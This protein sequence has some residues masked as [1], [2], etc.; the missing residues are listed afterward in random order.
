MDFHIGF[1]QIIEL[2]TFLF[3]CQILMVI[4]FIAMVSQKKKPTEMI[5][6][7]LAI[8]FIPYLAIPI[9]LIFGIRKRKNNTSK[10]K[11]IRFSNLECSYSSSEKIGLINLFVNEDMAYPTRNN[12]FKLFLN[13]V[14]AYN[15]LISS[16]ANAKKNI[17]MST[18]IFSNDD[19]SKKII[20]LLEIKAK[21]GIKIKILIDSLGSYK[22]YFRPHLFKKLKKLGGMVYFFMPILKSPFRNYINY[23]NHRKIYIFD[24]KIVFSGGM[25]IGQEYLGPSACKNRWDDILFYIKGDAVSRFHDVFSLDWEFATKEIISRNT[26]SGHDDFSYGNNLL[27][28]IPSGPDINYDTVY[29]GLLSLI[30]NAKKRVWIVTPYFVPSDSLFEA[31]II[32]HKRG[33]DVTVVTPIESNHKIADLARSS[34]MRQLQSK[35][36]KIALYHKMIHAKAVLIDG[37]TVMLGSINFDNRSLF[38][39]Y[40]IAL[41]AYQKQIIDA[42]E[43]W[44][45]ELIAESS[46][47]ILS[48]TKIRHLSENLVKVLVP[49]L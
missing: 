40:E 2:H 41:F 27:H 34:Y 33:V 11:K 45:N 38:L 43:L 20:N 47:K 49:L 24:D 14:E 44:M 30:H 19:V 9:Y 17:Y 16:I 8:I 10:K 1:I 26:V 13:G 31:I 21:Q 28:V 6:W 42:I 3:L 12:D 23:R 36:I 25:N 35:G 22:T 39:N 29:N 32:A 18:Y 7:S 5:A 46:N 48:P 37:T 4:F 15:A